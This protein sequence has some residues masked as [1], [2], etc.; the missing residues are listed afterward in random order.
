[1]VIIQKGV[2]IFGTAVLKNLWGIVQ[3]AETHIEPNSATWGKKPNF[4]NLLTVFTRVLLLYGEFIKKK[5]VPKGDIAWY[6]LSNTAVIAWN[7]EKT[8]GE[9]G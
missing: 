7:T 2:E 5:W 6:L 4:A 9:L 3:V 1:M 8:W